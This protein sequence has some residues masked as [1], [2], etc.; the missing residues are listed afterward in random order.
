[1]TEKIYA[2]VG[3][4][5][6]PPE[7]DI[8]FKIDFREDEG[9]PARVFEIASDL[10]RA[11]EDL[12]SVLVTSVDSKIS[13]SMILEDVEK[14]SLKIFLRNRLKSID[15]GALKELDWKQQVGAFLVKAKYIA[16]EWLDKKI[17][18]DTPPNIEDL[19]ERLRKLAVET[20][21][22]HMPD[23][24][25]INLPRLAQSLDSIQ[26][27]KK[28]FKDG[29]ALTITLADRE[30]KVITTSDWLPSEH[31]PPVK[32]EQELSNDADMVLV[33]RRPDLLANAQWQFKHGKNSVSASI[34]HE[35]WLRE[36]HQR[37]HIIIPGDALKCRVR[38]LTKYDAKGILIDQKV[39]VIHVYGVIPAAEPPGR[40]FD[41]D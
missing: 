34:S 17:D 2:R 12:D 20:D 30:Y 36:Y 23:Y 35:E 26:R 22:K 10:I 29:E 41:E 7:S 33:V 11:F 31:L 27:T 16:I 14:S 32:M 28:K 37:R 25:P 38:F 8:E 18:A 21:A 1:M 19:S 3:E 15:D 6:V 13:T 5:I 9:S 24:A 4:S 39:E 40:L